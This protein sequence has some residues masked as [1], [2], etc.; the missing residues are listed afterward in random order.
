MIRVRSLSPLAFGFILFCF[1]L[2]FITVSCPGASYT[3]SGAQLVTGTT[4]STPTAFG[5][6]KQQTV[7]GEPLAALAAL[8][9]LAGLVLGL[10]PGA[11]FRVP[12]AVLAGLG[13]V[14]LLALRSKLV[15]DAAREGQG[16]LQLSFDL[17][18]WLAL[19]GFVA[20]A[21]LTWRTRGSETGALAPPQPSP[22][23]PQADDG[24]AEPPPNP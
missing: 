16:M 15:A 1:V 4:L 7:E 8:C 3:M 21:V 2:P 5:P 10:L 19:L 22:V 12:G 23:A 24:L 13:A 18:F 17:G 14:L 20:A 11:R 6:P 9:A